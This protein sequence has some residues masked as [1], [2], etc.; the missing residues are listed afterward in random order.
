MRR[1]PKG[2]VYRL[3]IARNTHSSRS[4]QQIAGLP[5]RAAGACPSLHTIHHNLQASNTSTIAA[6]VHSSPATR[7]PPKEERCGL[8]WCPKPLQSPESSSQS[9]VD[10]CRLIPSSICGRTRDW[11]GCRPGRSKGTVGGFPCFRHRMT[12]IGEAAEDKTTMQCHPS[13]AVRT[14]PSPTKWPMAVA[15]AVC[16]ERR[17]AWWENPPDTIARSHSGRSA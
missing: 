15:H 7:L 12:V 9:A 8:S 17:R 6:K 10:T 13:T 11:N 5:N 2:L 1:A 3:T 14:L 4:V 16:R